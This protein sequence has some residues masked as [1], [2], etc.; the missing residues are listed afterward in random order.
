MFE[1][2]VQPTPL[3]W[4]VKVVPTGP[5][6][7]S[8]ENAVGLIQYVPVFFADPDS[9]HIPCAP[10]RSS[11]TAKRNS[12]CPALSALLSAMAVDDS[13][14]PAP[15]IRLPITRVQLSRWL[16]PGSKPSP[17][18]TAGSPTPENC[19]VA[20]RSPCG[21]GTRGFFCACCSGGGGITGAPAVTVNGI[22]QRGRSGSG[23]CCM[24]R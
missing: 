6:L 24:L 20:T 14:Q 23:L 19:G 18:T 16:L 4:T 7:I 15:V 13:S 10:P 17:R 22:A 21:G 3:R 11:G 8:S 1:V 9:I 5:R 2:S 12:A